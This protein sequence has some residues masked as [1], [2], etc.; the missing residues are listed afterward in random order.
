[1]V[2]KE[3]KKN[4]GKRNQGRDRSSAGEEEEPEAML[5]THLIERKEPACEHQHLEVS[6]RENKVPNPRREIPEGLP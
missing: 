1:M 5:G 2:L 3:E 4:R 6:G